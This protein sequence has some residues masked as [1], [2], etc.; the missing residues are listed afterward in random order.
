M[1]IRFLCENS[2]CRKPLR[3][4]DE[5]AGKRVRCPQC[6]QLV[7]A[8]TSSQTAGTSEKKK[9]AKPASKAATPAANAKRKRLD[10]LAEELEA[11]PEERDMLKGT[12]VTVL[13]S[14]GLV[15]PMLAD[16]EGTAS[17]HDGAV[18]NAKESVQS[19]VRV[20]GANHRAVVLVQEMLAT[21]QQ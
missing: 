3:V 5:L 19:A 20:L 9:P 17:G 12:M 6:A 21:I 15:L 14:M 2:D 16:A 13:K 11:L 7:T 8:P 18:Q 1:P 10:A 4:R